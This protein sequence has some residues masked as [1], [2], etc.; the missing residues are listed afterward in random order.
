MIRHLVSGVLGV[1]ALSLVT[2]P[3]SNARDLTPRVSTTVLIN[4][5]STQ[6]TAGALDEYLELR[7]VSTI[8]VDLS[9]FRLQFYSL[10]CVP[11]ET[12]FLFQGL[13]LQP[14]NSVGQYLVLIGQNF[15]GSIQDPTNV[16]P[17]GNT[18]DLIPT[19]AGAVVLLDTTGRRVDTAGWAPPPE[20]PCLREGQP[21]STPPPGLSISRNYLS[22][23]SDNNRTDFNPTPHTP[24]AQW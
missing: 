22:W 8:P 16:I 11:A 19:R 24:G 7:N 12:V 13:V 15:S 14:M 20:T 4:E 6:G 2:A 5:V 21:A 3:P 9:G 18:G 10:S 23:D 1:L 17:V